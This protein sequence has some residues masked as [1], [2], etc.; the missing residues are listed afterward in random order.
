[1]WFC[2]ISRLLTEILT[3]HTLLPTSLTR[4]LC[5]HGYRIDNYL[6]KSIVCSC[7]SSVGWFCAFCKWSLWVF[8]I[9]KWDIC[10]TPDTN[11]VL[12]GNDIPILFSQQENK[13]KQ[14]RRVFLEIKDFPFESPP[15]SLA[16]IHL[17]HYQLWVS[18]SASSNSYLTD[19][20]Q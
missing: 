12:W 16:K 8:F 1:M 6:T 5:D 20:A 2:T 18:K 13:R 17:M 19:G 4:E 10:R 14:N 3:L 15:V 7:I 11:H 9:G